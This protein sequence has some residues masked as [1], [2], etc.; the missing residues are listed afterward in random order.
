MDWKWGMTDI[1]RQSN[2][3]WDG[4]EK[5]KVRRK[6]GEVKDSEIRGWGKIGEDEDRELKGEYILHK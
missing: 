6:K 5:G 3:G 2:E 1:P 4:I